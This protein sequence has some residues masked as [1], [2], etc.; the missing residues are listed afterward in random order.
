MQPGAFHGYGGAQQGFGS[1]SLILI[2][3]C[4]LAQ[5][6]LERKSLFDCARQS[7]KVIVEGVQGWIFSLSTDCG[8]AGPGRRGGGSQSREHTM[9]GDLVLQCEG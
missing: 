7:F 9:A 1:W 5:M 4:H 6:C 2:T 3:E 8:T